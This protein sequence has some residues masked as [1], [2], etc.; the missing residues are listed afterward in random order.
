[1]Q[2]IVAVEKILVKNKSAAPNFQVYSS[3]TAAVI[4]IGR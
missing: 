3:H 4:E 2:I 1:M